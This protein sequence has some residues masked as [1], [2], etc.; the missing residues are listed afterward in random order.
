MSNLDSLMREAID[1]SLQQTQASKEMSDEVRNKMEGIDNKVDEAV[2]SVPSTVKKL[3]D[4]LLY[5][6]P[7]DGSD[8]NDGKSAQKPL[9]SIRKAVGLVPL[10]GAARI[11][12]LFDVENLDGGLLQPNTYHKVAVGN[13]QIII[14]LNGHTWHV[15]T[16]AKNSWQG[17]T[18]ATVSLTSSFTC[19]ANGKLEIYNG[20]I[21]VRHLP[22]HTGKPL[23]GHV[24]HN[25]LIVGDANRLSLTTLN[26]DSD[27][28]DLGLFGLDNYGSVGFDCHM[29]EVNLLGSGRFRRVVNLADPSDIII[30]MRSV[31]SPDT[32][33]TGL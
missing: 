32:W 25:S 2:G 31:S 6:H 13:R 15:K 14:D 21:S 23:Y 19:G 4:Q 3:F 7:L 30:K 27:L 20:K 12:M 16:V 10:G 18:D 17:D 33:L 9:K 22:E 24:I 5:V 29:G 8:S 1:A 26:I 11:E 28:P